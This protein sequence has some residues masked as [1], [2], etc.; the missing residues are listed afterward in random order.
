[1]LKRINSLLDLPELRQ[2]LVSLPEVMTEARQLLHNADGQVVSLGGKLAGAA[3]GAR[4]AMETL[5]LVLSDVQKLVRNVDGQVAPLSTGAKD[6]LTA[7]R[8][9]LAQA[10]KSLLT[11]TDAATPVLKQSEK[12]LAGTTALIGPD[13]PLLNDLDRTLK[14]LEETAKSIRALTDMLQRNPEVLLR[15]KT[16]LEADDAPL[17]HIQYCG[18]TRRLCARHERLRQH[19][20]DAV[21]CPAG[22]E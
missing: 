22:A 2:T 9:A 1:M 11:L 7:T 6:T 4:T 18:H 3:E 8:S 14:A 5:R 20:T 15:G 19:P 17:A 13:S 16:R 10:Q 21:L 12:T